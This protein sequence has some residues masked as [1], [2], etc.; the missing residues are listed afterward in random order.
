MEIILD[1]CDEDTRSEISFGP[2]Y[3]DNLKT[4]E[5]IKLLRRLRKDCDDTEDKDVFLGPV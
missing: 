2:S 4:G 5:L 1:Q 3:E